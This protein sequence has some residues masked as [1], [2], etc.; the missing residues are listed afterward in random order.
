MK[1]ILTLCVGAILISG[2]AAYGTTVLHYDFEDGTPNTPMNPNPEDTNTGLIGTV[3]LSG[4]DYHMYAWNDY[5]GPMFSSEGD[6]PSGVGLSS[7]HDGHRDG[8]A[9]AE[10]LRT[11]SPST[12]TIELSFKYD[13]PDGW[14]TLIGKDGWTT[15]P[16]DIAAG[17]YIQSNGENNAMRVNFA[18]V[19]NERIWVD[20]SLIPESGQWYHFAVVVDGDQINMYADQFDG[21]GFQNIGSLTMDAGVDHSLQPT[22]TWTFGRGWFN[23][24][25]VDH[26]SGNLD[27]IRFSDVALTTDQLIPEPATL[28]LLGLGSLMLR[29]RRK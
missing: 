29:R 27:N 19:S 25:F 26:I 13:N 12:W 21:L 5:F 2:V 28:V 8:Y 16:G 18:T 11:W 3:D 1:N 22:G 7:F 14:R 17:M 9:W 20:S 6:T 24:A 10:G 23:D 15:I 4:N